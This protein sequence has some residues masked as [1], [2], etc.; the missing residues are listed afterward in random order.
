M[1]KA[2]KYA[3][4]VVRE[5][6]A[7]YAVITFYLMSPLN[8][9]SEEMGYGTRI[10]MKAQADMKG[11]AAGR[12]YC[13]AVR[14]NPIIGEDWRDMMRVIPLMKRIEKKLDEIACTEGEPKTPCDFLLRVARV[15]KIKE[16]KTAGGPMLPIDRIA[17]RLCWWDNEYQ[18]KAKG[19]AA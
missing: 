1:K 10:E 11:V 19:Q 17:E 8:P 3:I 4:N 7:D 14:H 12:W 16:G 15:L 5:F 6:D 13:F 18:V 9:D 2:T